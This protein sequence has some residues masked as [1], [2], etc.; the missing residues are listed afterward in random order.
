MTFQT[1]VLGR[2][3]IM[4]EFPDANIDPEYDRSDESWMGKDLLKVEAAPQGGTV[5]VNPRITDAKK[6]LEARRDKVAA[7]AI[8]GMTV[9][10]ISKELGVTTNAVRKD[11]AVRCITLARA[12]VGKSK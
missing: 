2:R 12:K 11:A 10:Q 5:V 3:P 8:K 7:M 4:R 6:E 9:A 1:D